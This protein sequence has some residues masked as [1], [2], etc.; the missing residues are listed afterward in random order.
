MRRN[1]C[2]G[3]IAL[4]HSDKLACDN[5]LNC[6][7]EIV[8]AYGRDGYTDK[9]NVYQFMRKVVKMPNQII[10]GGNK[11]L[12]SEPTGFGRIKLWD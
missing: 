12:M 4:V 10:Y 5:N 7:Y 11:K 6:T 2:D 8:H 9:N 1:R 3:H